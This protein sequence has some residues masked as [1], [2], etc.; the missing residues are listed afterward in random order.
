MAAAF[1]NDGTPGTTPPDTN[2]PGSRVGDI[3]ASLFLDCTLGDV[4]FQV[5][6]FDTNATQTILSN[7]ANAVIPKG[8]AAVVGNAHTLR[9]KWDPAAHLLT[10]QADGQAPVVVDP[11]TV[12]A[13]MNTAAPYVKPANVPNTN[14][15][16]FM[17]FPNAVSPG[18]TASV[19]F[20]A[21]NV[22]TAP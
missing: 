1:Y 13:R 17:F 12:N 16:W 2:Q 5:T 21:N 11:T 7:S 6:R 18:A 22:F 15:D 3:T 19:D 20:R 9:M 10:F 14:L 8:P 4:R